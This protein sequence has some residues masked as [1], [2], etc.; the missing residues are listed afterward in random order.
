MNENLQNF[1][2]GRN[3]AKKDCTS[4]LT[5]IAYINSEEHNNACVNFVPKLKAMFNFDLP[6]QIV[7][8]IM[9]YCPVRNKQLQNWNSMCAHLER[10]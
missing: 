5:K 2:T 1:M 9:C 8:F 3:F 7:S 10:M 4:D 6:H